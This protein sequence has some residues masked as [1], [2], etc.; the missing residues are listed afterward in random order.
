MSCNGEKHA[1][2]VGFGDKVVAEHSEQ[3]KKA[4]SL[5]HQA[6]NVAGV[7]VVIW[8]VGYETV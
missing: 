1:V 3:P 4:P 8:A 7:G 2:H 5:C 6:R